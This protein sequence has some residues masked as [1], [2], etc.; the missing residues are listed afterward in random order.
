MSDLIQ[1]V[2]YKIFKA[3]DESDDIK[4]AEQIIALVQ[5]DERQRRDKLLDIIR[6]IKSTEESY[7]DEQTVLGEIYAMCREAQE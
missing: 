4:Y 1:R 3:C 5:E 2:A 7:D 6:R